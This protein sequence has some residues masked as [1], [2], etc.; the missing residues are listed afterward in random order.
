[1]S[2]PAAETLGTIDYTA[3]EAAIA[4]FPLFQDLPPDAARHLASYAHGCL[5]A[6]GARLMRQG[7]PGRSFHAILRGRVRVE[8]AHPDLPTPVV[9]AE[10]G[11]GEVVGEMGALD[12]QPR[13]ATVVAVEPTETIELEPSAMDV[14]MAHY[15]QVVTALA[16]TFS[17]RLRDTDARMV[18]TLRQSSS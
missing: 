14:L 16:L 17:A 8:R 12:G 10:L 11:P 1:M 13:S 5:F 9:L 2:L 6:P 15:Q 7:D 18:E 4:A 3:P